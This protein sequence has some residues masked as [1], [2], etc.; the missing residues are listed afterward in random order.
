MIIK[1]IK[2]RELYTVS[3]GSVRQATNDLTKRNVLM[4][5]LEDMLNTLGIIK[6]SATSKAIAQL[7]NTPGIQDAKIFCGKTSHQECEIQITP[8]LPIAVFQYASPTNQQAVAFLDARGGVWLSQQS[9]VAELQQTLPNLAIVAL[10][11]DTQMP[12]SGF[13]DFRDKPYVLHGLQELQALQPEIRDY[14]YSGKSGWSFTNANKTRII[15]GHAERANIIREK[16]QL[17]EFIRAERA[18][19][20]ITPKVID[21]RFLEAPS[22][23]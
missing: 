23:R 15:V 13:V 9:K 10:D 5:N 14:I 12:T 11:T 16:L 21:V 8:S 18:G 20:G 6:E 4:L 7:R 1:E 17:A 22:Y 3:Y 19:K 2:V